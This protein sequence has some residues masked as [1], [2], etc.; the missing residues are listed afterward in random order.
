[1]VTEVGS[2][3]RPWSRAPIIGA[4]SAQAVEP[5]G[6]YL[7]ERERQTE[8]QKTIR[9]KIQEPR[10]HFSNSV[11]KSEVLDGLGDKTEGFQLARE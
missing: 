3:L 5:L 9:T 7:V 4:L 6:E 10:E 1:M 2:G 8:K 11:V